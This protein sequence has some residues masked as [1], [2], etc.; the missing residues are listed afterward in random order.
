MMTPEHIPPRRTGNNK[1][2]W[3][4]TMDDMVQR[5][6]PS[7]FDGGMGSFGLCDD[8]NR[9]TGGFYGDA[10]FA[11]HQ[12]IKVN[13]ND[14][15]GETECVTV[16]TQ[17]LNVLKQILV[18]ALAMVGSA[19]A[20]SSKIKAEIAKHRSLRN[21]VRDPESK[22]MP[23]EYWVHCYL[24]T[25]RVPR[26]EK[27]T[28]KLN[29]VTGEWVQILCEFAKPPLGYNVV[30]YLP[31]VNRLLAPLAVRRHKLC[32]IN[33][34]DLFDFNETATLKLQMPR[35][36]IPQ[37]ASY[38]PLDYRTD[39]EMLVYERGAIVDLLRERYNL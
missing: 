28:Q 22:A 15:R 3:V 20:E 33:W 8:C 32:Y 14:G 9:E 2:I 11:W 21:F 23:K 29:D 38:Y 17:P 36:N 30:S 39:D 26:F 6:S 24:T 4:P 12:Q 1:T 27:L 7:R 37:T 19:E 10:Y 5:R 18:M 31:P 16:T 25:S 34:F 35:L 13:I